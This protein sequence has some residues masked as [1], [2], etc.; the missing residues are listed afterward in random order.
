MLK[1]HQKTLSLEEIIT[2]LLLAL[3]EHSTSFI[4]QQVE[5]AVLTIPAY[6]TEAQRAPVRNAA[7]AA[8]LEV[9]RIINE[10]T[11]AAIACGREDENGSR[12]IAIFDLGGGT[13]DVSV[14][15]IDAETFIKATGGDIFLG[16]LDFDDRVVN[17]I[18]A[19]FLEKTGIDLAMDATAVARIRAAAESA[20]IDLSYKRETRVE[21][22]FIYQEEEEDFHIGLMILRSELET[23]TI[24]LVERSVARFKKLLQQAAILLNTIDEVLLVGGQS[25]M[26]LVKNKVSEMG[27]PTP[28]TAIEPEQAVVMGA[29][30]MADALQGNPSAQQLRLND[31]LPLGI[32]L[33][34]PDGKPYCFVSGE[35]PLPNQRQ[36]TLRAPDDPDNKLPLRFSARADLRD[37]ARPQQQLSTDSIH[38]KPASSKKIRN[39][40]SKRITKLRAEGAPGARRSPSNESQSHLCVGRRRS[41]EH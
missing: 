3:T 19:D 10:P 6:F 22:P 39:E 18:M 12:R 20:K 9:L 23:L 30:M 14:I 2:N 27:I 31:L 21:I 16:G 28:T 7:E 5:Q 35:H 37:P 11:A 24:D 29:A 8:G 38:C 17:H 4:G 1:L 13:F 34:R 41:S 33:I 40:R 26:P 15:Q 25:R 36:I 32:H